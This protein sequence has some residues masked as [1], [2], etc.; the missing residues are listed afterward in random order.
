VVV[1]VEIPEDPAVAE[2]RHDRDVLEKSGA[3]GE[4]PDKE[5][6]LAFLAGQASTVTTIARV[7]AGGAVLILDCVDGPYIAVGMK[8][9]DASIHPLHLVPASGLSERPEAW[10]DPELIVAEECAEEMQ[11]ISSDRSAFLRLEF[12][13]ELDPRTRHLDEL[14]L[15]TQLKGYKRWRS[16]RPDFPLPDQRD[17]VHASLQVLGQDQ[18]C[19]IWGTR[20]PVGSVG[21]VVID[22]QYGAIDLMGAVRVRTGRPLADVVLLDGEV[23]GDRLLDRDIFVFA[24]EEFAKL[25]FTEEQARAERHYKSGARGGPVRLT[26]RPHM[27]PP[28]LGS[29]RAALRCVAPHIAAECDRLP[30]I[31]AHKRQ[32]VSWA[33]IE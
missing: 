16:L 25:V 1:F 32:P 2:T 8:D 17:A 11:I 22:A 4:H 26:P 14:V 15:D 28:L 29:A 31:P 13:V 10:L 18:V 6:L 21:C 24:P 23:V 19:S 30:E 7:S 3:S 27:N 12:A 9:A 20:R 5:Q 33:R